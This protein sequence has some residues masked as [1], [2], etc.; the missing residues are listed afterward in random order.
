M[1]QRIEIAKD[2]VSFNGNLSQLHKELSGY[3]WD[4][5]DPILQISTSDIL[6]ILRKAIT[7][8]IDF[9]ELE[10]WANLIECRDDF[11]FQNDGLQ[12][13]IFQLANPILNGNITKELL[14]S[15]EIELRS[16]FPPQAGRLR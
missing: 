14:V 2:I 8:E 1:R 4:L 9:I 10:N 16:E 5:E 6:N 11:S 15:L 13:I 3:S 12:E 7:G